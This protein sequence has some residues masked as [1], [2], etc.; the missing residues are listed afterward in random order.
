[1]V[2]GLQNGGNRARDVLCLSFRA[3]AVSFCALQ[4]SIAA[5]R[6]KPVVDGA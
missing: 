3:R 6:K 5:A 2:S 1:M 4:F